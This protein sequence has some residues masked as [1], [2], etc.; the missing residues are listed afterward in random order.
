MALLLLSIL[1]YFCLPDPLFNDPRST[2]LLDRNGELLGATI[3]SDG[4]WRF[5]M[6]DSLPE[7]F[8][9]CI[10]EFEDR[11]FYTHPGFHLPSFFRAALQNLKEGRVVSGGSTLTM[12]TIRMSRKGKG[13]TVFEKLI[14]LVLSTRLE[15]RYSK[16]KILSHYTANAPFGGNVV[17]LEAAAWRYYDRSPFDLS[18]SETATLAV[19]PN[20]PSLIHPGR[21]RDALLAKRSRLIDR[22][23]ASGAID[24]VSAELAKEEPLPGKP[25]PLPQITPHLLQRCIAEGK[26]GTRINS[27]I[28]K[29]IQEHCSKL[30]ADHIVGLKANEI[31]NAAALV[32]DLNDGNVLAYIGNAPLSLG[33]HGEQVDIITAPR[34]TGSILKPL[35]FAKMLDEGEILSSMLILDIPTNIGG[36]SPKNFDMKYDGAV[37]ANKALSRSLNIPAVR[38][39]RLHGVEKFRTTLQN[40]GLHYINKPASHYGLTLVIGGAESS[41]WDIAKAY[42]Y[43]SMTLNNFTQ[44]GGTY[45]LPKSNAQHIKYFQETG[46]TELEP[47]YDP[48]ISAGAIH[49]TYKALLDVNRPG[50][51]MGWE[52]M[53]SSN[54]IAWKTGTSFGHRDAWAVGTTARYVVAVWIGNADGEGRP[55][56]TGVSNAA[57]LMF[58]LFDALIDNEWF[59]TPHDEL[60]HLPVCRKS[61]YRPSPFCVELDTIISTQSGQ[62]TVP[63]PYHKNVHIDRNSGMRT[64]SNCTDISNIETQSWFVL[65][66]AVEWYYKGAHPEYRSL[67][68][69][70]PKC[71]DLGIGSSPMQVIQ[72]RNL[73]IVK[74]PQELDGSK[75]VLVFEVAH[76]QNGS[77]IFWHLDDKYLG[78]T[79]ELHQKSIR[80]NAGMHVLTLVDSWGNE[81]VERFEVVE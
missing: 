15:L 81:L 76:R 70:D 26:K 60:I 78:E 12:Q 46:S 21:N 40:A 14:E 13:R 25:K 8:K 16:D 33:E 10:I 29:N 79:V 2:V 9:T 17:G 51:E 23:L 11:T 31:H 30:L 5:P 48:L 72:P 65:P 57:P 58:Q 24:E 20:A 22:L 37:P 77:N 1:Y 36:F 59:E 73:N 54:K 45:S 66:P 39:L 49:I 52:N 63:C 44:N 38:M 19:L 55:G 47:N 53:T 41:L 80:P 62:R 28:N 32:I 27:T 50:S 3:A 4:Q 69:F 34:S 74:I 43:M 7:K 18:W 6:A 68:P 64:S 75:S 56:N 71:T 61:G 35:L 42:S 67:P